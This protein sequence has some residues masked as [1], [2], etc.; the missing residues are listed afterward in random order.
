MGRKRTNIKMCSRDK[1]ICGFDLNGTAH[2]AGGFI[3]VCDSARVIKRIIQIHAPRSG[4]VKINGKRNENDQWLVD[5][6]YEKS[7]QTIVL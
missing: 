3:A 1:G 2:R 7:S 5:D 4:A 6:I